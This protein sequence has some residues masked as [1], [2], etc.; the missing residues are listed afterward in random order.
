[1]PVETKSQKEI[2]KEIKQIQSWL[3]Y[4]P[5]KK[6]CEKFSKSHTEIYGDRHFYLFSFNRSAFGLTTH[7]L[8]S[9]NMYNGNILD[10]IN[11]SL[12][13][14]TFVSLEKITIK[15]YTQK[16]GGDIPCCLGNCEYEGDWPPCIKKD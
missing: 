8:D 13:E 1:M 15:E 5:T 12:N 2:D 3:D 11:D 6:Q 16:G 9:N 4:K 14:G 7:T 10:L